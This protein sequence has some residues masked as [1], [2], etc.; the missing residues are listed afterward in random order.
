M[1]STFN[2]RQH[3]LRRNQGKLRKHAPKIVM[4]LCLHRSFL[5]RVLLIVMEP[6]LARSRCSQSQVLYKAQCHTKKE[7]AEGHCSSLQRPSLESELLNTQS[8]MGCV[9]NN[10][11]L[12]I[13]F[14]ELVSDINIFFTPWAFLFGEE[15]WNNSIGC[16]SACD[17]GMVHLQ[18][19]FAQGVIEGTQ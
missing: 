6:T 2:H 14:N 9:F 15:S 16:L 11:S 8:L 5:L 19:I 18:E 4:L 7:C 3:I 1:N 10:S 12:K 17:T 13:V